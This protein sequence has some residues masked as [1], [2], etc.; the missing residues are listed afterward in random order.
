M[1]TENLPQTPQQAARKPR[2]A[3][4]FGGLSASCIVVSLMVKEKSVGPVRN[5][6]LRALPIR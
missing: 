4:V 6:G 3:V 1:S 2:V 5:H